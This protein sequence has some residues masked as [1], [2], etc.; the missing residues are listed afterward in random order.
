M[1]HRTSQTYSE[2][3]RKAVVTSF[4]TFMSTVYS[5]SN[6]VVWQPGLPL[7]VPVHENVTTMIKAAMPEI[8]TIWEQEESKMV[9][10]QICQDLGE[11]LKL[12]GPVIIVEHVDQIA[13]NCLD[14]YHKKALSTRSKG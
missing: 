9:V 6:P 14:I 12:C 13:N 2:G 4:T 5:M 7:K 11:A 8:L 10:V 3:I 1:R